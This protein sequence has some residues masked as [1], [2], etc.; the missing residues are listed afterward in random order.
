M[1]SGILFQLFHHALD[2]LFRVGQA[3]HDDLDVHDRLAGPALALAIDAVLA[4]QGHGVS[5]RVHGDGEATAGHAH[6]GFV[7]FQFLLLF[8]EYW[9]ATIVTAT[10]HAA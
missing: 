6:H 4:N 2:Q 10:A 5:D 9:H 8:V 1:G 7:V 3:L